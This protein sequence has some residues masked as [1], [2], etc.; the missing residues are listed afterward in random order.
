MGARINKTDGQREE[1]L[2]LI[3][4]YHK[5]GLSQSEIATRIGCSRPQIHY[6]MQTLFRRWRE[7]QMD[8][9]WDI[10][11]SELAKLDLLENTAWDEWERSRLD[12]EKNVTK[13]VE[14]SAIDNDGQLLKL[15]AEEITRTVAGQAGDPRFLEIIRKCIEDRR[16]IYGLDAPIKTETTVR[17]R[18]ERAFIFQALKQKYQLSTN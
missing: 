6:D 15:P 5:D 17:T 16:K 12:A 4:Q 2:A 13:N 3:A 7:E 9:I 11:L 18:E 1:Q 10:R 14:V 8:K